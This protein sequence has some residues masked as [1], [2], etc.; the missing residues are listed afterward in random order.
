[1]SEGDKG[2]V[3]QF[4]RDTFTDP[5]PDIQSHTMEGG[6]WTLTSG[7]IRVRSEDLR[8][9]DVVDALF[10]PIWTHNLRA[11]V[12]EHIGQRGLWRAMWVI[13]AG[14]YVGQWAMIPEDPDAFGPIIWTPN[15]DLVRSVA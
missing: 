6:P 4:V 7:T 1:M 8:Q 12:A 10:A 3:N 11:G 5:V 2:G 13:E 14:E 15:C 9:F